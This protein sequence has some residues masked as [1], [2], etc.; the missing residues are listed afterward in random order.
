MEEKRQ[1]DGKI[2]KTVSKRDSMDAATH[3]STAA[4]QEKVIARRYLRRLSY[5]LYF[6]A[7]LRKDSRAYTYHKELSARF[8]K[9]ITKAY[10][11]LE[12]WKA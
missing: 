11:M 8:L 7:A 1:R 4:R 10:E 5:D 3:L 6:L 12:E 9:P 2:W